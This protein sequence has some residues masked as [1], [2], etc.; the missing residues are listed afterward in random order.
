MTRKATWILVALLGASFFA[1][2][3][4]TPAP[5]EKDREHAQDAI[6]QMK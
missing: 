6:D 2:C 3:A 1:A 4:P 5:G